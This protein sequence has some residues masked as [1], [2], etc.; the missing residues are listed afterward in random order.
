MAKDTILITAHKVHDE[1]IKLLREYRL[2]HTNAAV[3]VQIGTPAAGTIKTVNV[4]TNDKIKRGQIVV[5]L[6]SSGAQA[7]LSPALAAVHDAERLLTQTNQ[8][9]KAQ[10][11]TAVEVSNA[12]GAVN[13]R[14]D[15][16]V[17]AAVARDEGTE[18]GGGGNFPKRLGGT[19]AP[20]CH[21][22]AR[23]AIEG[24]PED[25]GPL[26]GLRAGGGENKQER[27]AGRGGG[28]GFHFEI[29]RG[30]TAKM[31]TFGEVERCAKVQKNQ[32]RPGR[33]ADRGEARILRS[34]SIVNPRATP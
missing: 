7:E 30:E 24:R 8:L 15:H 10:A 31:E 3:T 29:R 34:R 23:L 33:F 9:F 4:D 28:R 6:D 32:D 20:W 19:A 22:A 26:A 5:T 18:T 17:G 14:G 11:A 25:V 21:R 2:V 16:G 27:E 1:A 13:L 12:R